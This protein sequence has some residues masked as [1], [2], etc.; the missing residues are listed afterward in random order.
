MYTACNRSVK[1]YPEIV[2]IRSSIPT[3]SVALS[4]IINW[5]HSLQFPQEFIDCETFVSVVTIVSISNL[6][7]Y[8]FNISSCTILDMYSLV[9]RWK[10]ISPPKITDEILLKLQKEF[11]FSTSNPQTIIRMPFCANDHKH[12][13]KICIIIILFVSKKFCWHFIAECFFSLCWFIIKSVIT[14]ENCAH[15]SW[16]CWCGKKHF[17]FRIKFKSSQSSQWSYYIH[18]MKVY[19]QFLFSL[20]FST[21]FV[22]S[23]KCNLMHQANIYSEIALQTN[24]NSIFSWLISNNVSCYTK[25]DLIVFHDGFFSTWT[26][27]KYE[28]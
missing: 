1:V 15:F 22:Y 8:S 17:I 26:V 18:S 19:P 5:N 13:C 25:S 3:N 21:Q 2:A 20:L 4:L 28:S 12:L 14:T 6:A 27:E 16:I 23:I 10:I 7:S 24:T 11:L 9:F